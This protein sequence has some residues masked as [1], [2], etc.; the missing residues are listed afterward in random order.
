M[1][2][3]PQRK[4]GLICVPILLASKRK[5]TLIRLPGLHAH[6]AAL[7]LTLWLIPDRCM[8]VDLEMLRRIYGQ[9]SLSQ[10]DL[11]KLL[12]CFR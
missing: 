11:A 4:H 12:Q 10:L 9:V 8:I 7:P 1:K 3:G 2:L 5:K 6:R